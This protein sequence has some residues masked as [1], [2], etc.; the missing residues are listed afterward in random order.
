MPGMWFAYLSGQA[1][2]RQ[3]YPDPL[4]KKNPGHDPMPLLPLQVREVYQWIAPGS[5]QQ[6]VLAYLLVVGAMNLHI[7]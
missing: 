3:L 2:H 1:L 4:C 6:L 5:G 7:P